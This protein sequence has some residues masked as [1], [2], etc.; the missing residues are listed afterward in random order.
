MAQTMYEH[1]HK[2]TNKKIQTWKNNP[3][4]S[5]KLSDSKSS[6]SNKSEPMAWLGKLNF[7]HKFSTSALHKFNIIVKMEKLSILHNILCELLLPADI[8]EHWILQFASHK[9]FRIRNSKYIPK[10]LLELV[11]TDRI[12]KIVFA[13]CDWVTNNIHLSL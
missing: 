9:N 7:C 1:M 4:E 5:E 11:L 8:L 6:K 2:W 10:V 3:Q 12:Y 13:M